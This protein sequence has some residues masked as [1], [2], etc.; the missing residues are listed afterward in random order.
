MLSFCIPKWDWREGSWAPGVPREGMI[1]EEG[2]G[3][4]EG[5]AQ[6][7]G[8]REKGEMGGAFHPGLPWSWGWR[9]RT[10]RA[11]LLSRNTGRVRKRCD[12]WGS[13][14]K[15]SFRSWDVRQ[16]PAEWPQDEIAC[17]QIQFS[18]STHQDGRLVARGHVSFFRLFHKLIGFVGASL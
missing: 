16:W 6:S 15:P 2:W 1:L 10:L 13:N 7:A 4:K 17:F 3:L 8:R 9:T 14:R 11:W 5:F 18:P 12:V